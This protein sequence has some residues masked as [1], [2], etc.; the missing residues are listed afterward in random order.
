M[1][2]NKKLIKICK[3][4]QNMIKEYSGIDIYN[5][6]DYNEIKSWSEFKCN[7]ILNNMKEYLEEKTICSDR[8]ICPWCILYLDDCVKEDEKDLKCK[9]GKRHG[10]CKS[11]SSDYYKIH[12]GLSKNHNIN[13]FNDISNLRNK[14]HDIIYIK[15]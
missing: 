14:I 1:I 3:L 4:K 7:Y 10:Q 13:V 5:E 6:N 9:Y 12:L 2:S 11:R 8:D 15:L